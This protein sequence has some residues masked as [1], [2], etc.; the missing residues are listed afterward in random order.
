MASLLPPTAEG[1]SAVKA[2]VQPPDTEAWE[3]KSRDPSHFKSSRVPIE[4]RASV[5]QISL[6]TEH[7]NSRSPL[8]QSQWVAKLSPPIG[9]F[10]INT[11]LQISAFIAAIAFG[12]FAVK[13]VTVANDA[14]HYAAIAV[15]QAVTANQL[16]LL[17]VCLSSANQVS[18]IQKKTLSFWLYEKKDPLMLRTLKTNDVVAI[19]S[20]ILGG[21]SSML[22]SA[23]S[24]LFT[25]L[26]TLTMT[27]S[28]V[29]GEYSTTRYPSTSSIRMTTSRIPTNTT[30]STTR[31]LASSRTTRTLITSA[32]ATSTPSPSA[33]AHKGKT[34]KIAGI[35]VGTIL[36][37]LSLLLL[38]PYLL[39]RRRR[40]LRRARKQPN[41]QNTHDQ[42][43]PRPTQS[44]LFEAESTPPR[45]YYHNTNTNDEVLLVHER[46]KT[47]KKKGGFRSLFM[48]SYVVI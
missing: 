17:A 10:I 32:A 4:R 29:T 36:G 30:R 38:I 45:P 16:A 25:E 40:R 42:A 2:T 31:T 33:T 26:P 13:S 12:I 1:T 18:H 6:P 19:C 5:N 44:E 35:I 7:E 14:N 28:S 3:P 23:A 8:A 47:I 11:V 43:A 24:N 27:T 21:A 46:K 37:F 22:P 41:I 39:L 34:G 20:R 9:Q 48:D 15:Q